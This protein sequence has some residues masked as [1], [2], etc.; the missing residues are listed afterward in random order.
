MMAFLSC[1][2][3]FL[4]CSRG[5]SIL[6]TSLLAYAGAPLSLEVLEHC[7]VLLILCWGISLPAAVGADQ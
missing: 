6:Q 5:I 7:H 4:Y 1:S 3:D 2:H